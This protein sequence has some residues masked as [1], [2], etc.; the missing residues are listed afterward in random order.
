MLIDTLNERFGMNL[1]RRR[2][3]LVRTA[4]ASRQGL[5]PGPRRR[6]EQRP[7]PVPHLPGAFA[8]DAIIDRHEANGMLF[9]AFFEKPGFADALMEYLGGVYDEIRDEGAG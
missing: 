3:G 9:N 4:E 7:R 2:Q 8:Q 5:R 6:P 1:D